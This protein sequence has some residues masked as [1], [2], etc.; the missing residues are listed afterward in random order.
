MQARLADTFYNAE[1]VVALSMVR[2]LTLHDKRSSILLE[3]DWR[4]FAFGLELVKV[5]E[6][7]WG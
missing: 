4:R 1:I 3:R 6:F 2:P 7:T 5:M